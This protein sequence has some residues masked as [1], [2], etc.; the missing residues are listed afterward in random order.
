MEASYLDTFSKAWC[1]CYV[2]Q[3]IDHTYGLSIEIMV[4]FCAC[5]WSELL[6]WIGWCLAWN[7]VI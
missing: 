5:I 4:N 3:K 2:M 6:K 7:Y 1:Y